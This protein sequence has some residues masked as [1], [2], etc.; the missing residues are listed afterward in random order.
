MVFTQAM[1]MLGHMPD[2]ST[3]KASVNKPFAKHYIDT[4]DMLGEKTQGNLRPQEEQILKGIL[5]ELRELF[6][7]AKSGG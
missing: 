6:V 1:A 5:K 2:P 7:A 3:G 4:L